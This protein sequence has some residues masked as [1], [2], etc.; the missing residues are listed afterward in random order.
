MDDLPEGATPGNPSACKAV[1]GSCTTCP[2]L[3]KC[4]KKLGLPAEK[5]ETS[6]PGPVE[7][8]LIVVK[9]KEIAEHTKLTGDN[10]NSD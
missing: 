9:Q 10:T 7:S 5:V 4:R 1:D 8:R 3:S 6:A 2:A